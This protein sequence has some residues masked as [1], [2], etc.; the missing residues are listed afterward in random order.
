MKQEVYTMKHLKPIASVVVVL[1]LM[2]L[3][4]FVLAKGNSHILEVQERLKEEGHDPGPIDGILGGK[5][6]TALRQY[7]EKYEL[8]ITGTPDEA[9]LKSLGIEAPKAE[10]KASSD[11]FVI[12]VDIKVPDVE[13][14]T[15]AE[16]Q[17]VIDN[18]KLLIFSFD[19]AECQLEA[20]M[21]MT[22]PQNLIWASGA[23]H[24]YKGVSEQT[25]TLTS[26]MTFSDNRVGKDGLLLMV[27]KNGTTADF[28]RTRGWHFESDPDDPL[29]FKVVQNRGYVHI[30]GKGVAR[31]TEGKVYQLGK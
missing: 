17:Y 6:K 30:G 21:T 29:I 8:E 13:T 3:P 7:Q 23:E 10:T 28:N 19:C 20:M 27:S 25:G 1:G 16:V 18:Q 22:G 9:T 24:I 31:T 12:P 4:E 14:K 15:R 2:L 26:S 5:T 11:D